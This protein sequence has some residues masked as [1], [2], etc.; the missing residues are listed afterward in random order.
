MLDRP[1]GD[2]AF[3]AFAEASLSEDT[4]VHSLVKKDAAASGYT[5]SVAALV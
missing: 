4:H 1:F 2:S 3:E 5:V